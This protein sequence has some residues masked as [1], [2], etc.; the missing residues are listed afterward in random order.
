[1]EASL[2]SW[3]QSARTHLRRLTPPGG[4]EVRPEIDPF[5]YPWEEATPQ[6][7]TTGPCR[8]GTQNTWQSSAND[9]GSYARPA[10][11]ASNTSQPVGSSSSACTPIPGASSSRSH[12]YSLSA[13]GVFPPS[14]QQSVLTND[15]RASREHLPTWLAKMEGTSLSD[16]V[17]DFWMSLLVARKKL[18]PPPRPLAG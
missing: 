2:E 8:F 3:F 11:L 6:T 10:G 5:P 15:L 16:S 12:P 14:C 1:D 9:G 18:S 4:D 13:A 17:V 7:A